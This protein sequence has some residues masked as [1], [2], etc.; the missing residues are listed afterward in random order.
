[1]P[2]LGDPELPV[3]RG[4]S[5]RPDLGQQIASDR[6]IP[7]DASLDDSVLAGMG[8]GC[9]GLFITLEGVDGS[10]KTTQAELLAGALRAAGHDVVTTREPGGTSVGEGVRAALLDPSTRGLDPR[11]EALLYAAARAQLVEEVVRPALQEGRLVVCDRYIDSSLAYQGYARGLGFENIISLNMWAIDGLMPD[12]TLVLQVDER[13]RAARLRASAGE[14]GAERA[15][16]RLES[17][18]DGFFREVD[19]GYRRL[20]RDHPHRIRAVSGEGSPDEVHREI[21]SVIAE[22]LDLELAPPTGS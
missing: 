1:M 5:R 10:G 3:C 22:E 12:L 18:G 21:L 2:S 14:E 19:Q 11:A 13:T 7:E 15:P 8:S 17:E 20:V 4:G 16:D 9:R 6:E